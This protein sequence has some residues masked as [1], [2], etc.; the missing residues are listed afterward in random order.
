MT[1]PADR[2]LIVSELHSSQYPNPGNSLTL[3]DAW[4]GIYQTLLWYE[5]QL[6]HIIE[7]DKL[8]RNSTWQAKAKQAESFIAR[9]LSVQPSHL[10]RMVDRMMGLPRWAGMQRNNP[11]GTASELWWPRSWS[12]SATNS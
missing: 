9:S 4:L 5:H 8:K 2:A 12:Y 1:T 3:N 11:L 10:P 7:S 6:P